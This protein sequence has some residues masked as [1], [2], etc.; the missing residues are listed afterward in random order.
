ME[1]MY[2]RNWRNWRNQ[3]FNLLTKSSTLFL[4]ATICTTAA[5]ADFEENNNPD[6]MSKAG[7]FANNPL[8]FNHNFDSLPKS[9][10]LKKIPWPESYWPS[11]AGGI[12][13]RFQGNLTPTR[14]DLLFLTKKKLKSMSPE[15]IAKLSPTEKLDLLLGD[16]KFTF[17]KEEIDRTKEACGILSGLNKGW[18]GLCHG[19]SPASLQYPEPDCTTVTNPDGIEIKFVSSDLKALALYFVGE[20]SELKGCSCGTRCELSV[21]NP[22]RKKDPSYIDINPGAFFIVL[23]NLISNDQGFVMDRTTDSPIWNQPVF[24]FSTKVISDRKISNGRRE[25]DIELKVDWLVELPSNV[26][27]YGDDPRA[28]K[29]SIY[30]ATLEIDKDGNIDGGK[31]SGKSVDDHPDFIWMDPTDDM[32]KYGPRWVAVDKLLKEATKNK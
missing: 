8:K 27:P 7:K 18:W 30:T 31:W 29:N 4:I 6:Q 32:C 24:G 3:I 19:W 5:M 14:F 28:Q 9:A 13:N 17:T 12:R 1:T 10:R 20:V 15:K 25:V 21:L 26:K 16:Y 2:W 22:F 23:A 11:V